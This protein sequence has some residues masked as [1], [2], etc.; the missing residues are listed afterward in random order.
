MRDNVGELSDIVT[1]K[2]EGFTDYIKSLISSNQTTGESY[3]E[4]FTIF[5]IWVN[6]SFGNFVNVATA[7]LGT[8]S[9][10]K[11]YHNQIAG[12]VIQAK[13]GHERDKAANIGTTV[14]L[15]RD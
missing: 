10:Y 4:T 7:I 3:L 1:A 13:L 6:S 2:Q 12:A 14:A 5:C 15:A 11:T 9:H 8:V